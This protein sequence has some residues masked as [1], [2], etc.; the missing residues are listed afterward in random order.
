MVFIS[1]GFFEVAIEI[2]PE[3]ELNQQPLS[4]VQT[5]YPTELSGR[6]LNSH[7]ERTL[8]S[9]SN[10]IDCSVSHFFPAIAF[11]SGHVCFNRSFAEVMTR[12]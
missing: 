7:S 8:Y 1:E 6:E 2:W 9:Y 5:L 12:V 3:L 10:F 4:F 11:V